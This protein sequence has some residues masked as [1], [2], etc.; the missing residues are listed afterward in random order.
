MEKLPE[1]ANI[2]VNLEE[3]EVEHVDANPE[4][5]EQVDGPHTGMRYDS[6]E[7]IFQD[8]QE[9]AR[10]SGFSLLKRA[11][12]KGKYAYMACDKSRVPSTQ[13]IS[14][15]VGCTAHLNEIKQEDESWIISKI[16]TTHNQILIP[17]FYREQERL[18]ICDGD[19]EAIRKLFATLQ[20][21]DVIFFYMID[22]DDEGRLRNVLLIHP[23]SRAAYEDFN[24]VVSFDTTYL[25]N[26][27][28]MLELLLGLIIKANP[29]Y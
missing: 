2:D 22:I 12:S 17:E 21:R 18:R 14:K 11:L 15:R 10:K 19:A 3:E 1:L 13:K 23:R 7:S 9:Y 4:E 29:Y 26:K 8:Y 28:E 16:V 24:D 5:V 27:Y 25:V 6:F 20:H